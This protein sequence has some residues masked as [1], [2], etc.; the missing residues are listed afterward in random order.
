[1]Q[2]D[3]QALDT[4]QLFGKVFGL[5]GSEPDLL[6]EPIDP[7]HAFRLFVLI[8]GRAAFLPS[9]QGRSFHLIAIEDARR[10]EEKVRKDLA[11]TVFDTV[12]PELITAIPQADPA[13][14][15]VVDEHYAEEVR[16]AAMFLLYRL[17]FVLYAEDRNLLPDERGPYADY[18]LTRLRQEIAERHEQGQAQLREHRLAGPPGASRPPGP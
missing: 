7:E 16:Q 13:R 5:P 6:D 12:F 14:P 1:M 11:D 9:E 15:A 10:W 2:P 18:C 17:L 4:R 8:F 3:L